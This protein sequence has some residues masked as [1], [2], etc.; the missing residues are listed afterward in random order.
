MYQ[1]C[2]CRS[3]TYSLDLAP[4]DFKVFLVVKSDLKGHRFE[5][6]DELD[7]P[8]QCAVSFFDNEWCLGMF[9]Q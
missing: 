4:I 7:F 1:K 3:L 5:N 9:N 8:I 6:F 2:T